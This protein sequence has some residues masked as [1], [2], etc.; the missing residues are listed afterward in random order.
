MRN[1]TF[2]LLL[3]CIGIFAEPQPALELPVQPLLKPKETTILYK[4]GETIVPISISKYGDATYL[5]MINLHSDEVTSIEAAKKWLEVNGG[6][7]IRIINKQQR[8][9]RFRLHGRNYQFDPNRMFSREGITN[10]MSHLGRISQPA[11]AEAEKFGKRVLDLFPEKTSCIFALHN[12]T[13]GNFTIGN[14][15]P[16][17]SRESDAKKVNADA[18]KDPDD[19]FLT[20]DS[21]LYD[22]L[23]ADGYNIVWQDNVNA[24]KDGSLSIYCGERGIRYLNCETQHGKTDTYF[25][26]L[27]AACDHIEHDADEADF[28]SFVIEKEN[29]DENELT[30][31]IYFGERRV[32][33][34]KSF[35]IDTLSRKIN[36]KMALIKTFPLYSNLDFFFFTA[37][38]RF[39]ARFDPTREKKLLAHSGISIPIV[40]KQ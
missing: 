34:V 20:T 25:E 37:D 21:L 14:Y 3:S 5:T 16:G 12:N 8:N 38:K 40:V 15:L 10:N 22:G 36:G 11:I 35:S 30:H 19:L 9:I 39:E 6:V 32:G 17:S 23:S 2:F 4:L 24:K 7:M 28:I 33:T 18:G 29:L 1:V 27:S 31:A 13:E 26:M